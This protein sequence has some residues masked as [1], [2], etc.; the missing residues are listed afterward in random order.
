M[1]QHHN[2]SWRKTVRAGVLQ[3]CARGTRREHTTA[4]RGARDLIKAQLRRLPVEGRLQLCASG[5]RARA[6][7]CTGPPLQAPNRYVF[8]LILGLPHKRLD[9]A[10]DRGDDEV[11]DA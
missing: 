5:G 6:H 7:N 4:K 8:S 11:R 1:L 3:L 2:P 10:Y 9:H